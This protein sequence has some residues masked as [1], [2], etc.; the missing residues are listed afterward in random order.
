MAKGTLKKKVGMNQNPGKIVWL[1]ENESLMLKYE[2][3]ASGSRVHNIAQKIIP[4]TSGES[5]LDS[6]KTLKKKIWE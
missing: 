1:W 3:N 6:W 4:T 2:T 5:S